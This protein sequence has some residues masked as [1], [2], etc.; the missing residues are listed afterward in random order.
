MWPEGVLCRH[1]PSVDST[2]AEAARI[3]P[4]LTAPT[5]IIADVQTGARGRRGRAW[6]T[7]QGNLAATL[8]YRPNCTPQQAGLRSFMASVALFEA[9][10]MYVDRTRLSLKW[11]NDVLLDGGKVAGILLESSGKGPFID[12][13]AIGFGVNLAHVPDGVRDAAF[14]PVSLQDA[15]GTDAPPLHF[16]VRLAADFATQEAKLWEFGFSIIRRDWMRQAA[17][18]GDI[19]TARTARTEVTGTFDSIDAEGNLVLITAE[20]PQVISAADVYF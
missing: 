4:G 15:G 14:A 2:M 1:L 5:W 11:P 13:L 10:A 6:L 20:G 12:W 16:L 9:L 19:I 7:P 18:L 17:R 8:I 3:A